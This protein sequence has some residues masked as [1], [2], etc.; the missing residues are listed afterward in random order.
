M[1]KEWRRWRKGGA[2]GD[3]TD[4]KGPPQ[5]EHPSPWT[6]E[7]PEA[8]RTHHGQ[9]AWADKG[10]I[11]CGLPPSPPSLSG[12]RLSLCLSLSPRSLSLSLVHTW[13]RRGEVEVQK[14]PHL[15]PF[16]I[17]GYNLQRTKKLAESIW[18]LSSG[19]YRRK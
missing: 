1:E 10:R 14:E 16:F 6:W 5:G 17:F 15:W 12:V 2:A 8:G 19:S 9:P 4:R 7:L 3:Q 11:P 18:R 13:L